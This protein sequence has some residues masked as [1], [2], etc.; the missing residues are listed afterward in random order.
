MSWLKRR[1]KSATSGE[2]TI[3]PSPDAPLAEEGGASPSQG[4]V[5]SRDEIMARICEFIVEKSVGRIEMDMLEFDVHILDYGYIDSFNTC[6]LLKM[7]SEEFGVAINEREI[8]THLTTLNA[9]AAH[10]AAKQ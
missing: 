8:V 4:A 10:I 3:A 2:M 5:R 6:R 1:K 9:I 7:V